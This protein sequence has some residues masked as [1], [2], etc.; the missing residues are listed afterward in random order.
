[1]CAVKSCQIDW[2][3]RQRAYI[4]E[5]VPGWLRIIT[6]T[7]FLSTTQ[8]PSYLHRLLAGEAEKKDSILC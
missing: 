1:M 5:L 7:L 2:P 6:A 3:P 8:F 4:T